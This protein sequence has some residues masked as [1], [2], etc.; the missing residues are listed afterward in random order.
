MKNKLKLFILI[1]ALLFIYS[2]IMF[3]NWP[4]KV[5]TI[6][7]RFIIGESLGVDIGSDELS[8]GRILKGGEAVRNV[9][10]ENSYDY[11]VLVK[12]YISKELKDYIY[13]EN[14]IVIYPEEEVKLP[15]ILKTPKD[16]EMGNYTGEIKFEF[17]KYRE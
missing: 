17:R 1:I 14:N 15:F 12:V 10:L 6:K 4:I 3:L 2:F 16:I 9:L 8:F 11:P 7:V 5:E 13:S